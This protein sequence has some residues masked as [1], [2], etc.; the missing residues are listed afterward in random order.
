MGARLPSPLPP[1]VFSFTRN[2]YARAI[3]SWKHIGNRGVK[4][5][6]QWG[7]AR[8]AQLPGAYAAMCLAK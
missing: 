5:G 2:P 3:S 7:F 8:F 1:A 6:C 4:E